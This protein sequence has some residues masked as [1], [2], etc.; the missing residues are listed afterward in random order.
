MSSLTRMNTCS[1]ITIARIIDIDVSG[2]GDPP[3]RPNHKRQKF[4][5]HR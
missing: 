2:S 4:K 1:P 3:S 5:P